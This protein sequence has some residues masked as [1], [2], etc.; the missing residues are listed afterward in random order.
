MF[1]I[2]SKLVK[3]THK[4]LNNMNNTESTCN[5]YCDICFV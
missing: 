2:F 5:N 1:V 3:I 4:I